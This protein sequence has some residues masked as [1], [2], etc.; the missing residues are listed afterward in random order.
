[1]LVV[2]RYPGQRVQVRD[3][4]TGETFWIMVCRVI[5]DRGLKVRLGFDASDDYEILREEVI[6]SRTPIERRHAN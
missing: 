5:T 3:R 4:R 6:P 2:S 1:M